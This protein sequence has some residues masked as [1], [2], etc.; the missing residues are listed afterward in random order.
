MDEE[1]SQG[2]KFVVRDRRRFDS[3]G[4]ERGEDAMTNPTSISFEKEAVEKEAGAPE[5]TAPKVAAVSAKSAAS[6][7][8]VKMSKPQADFAMADR[9]P[10]EDPEI[11]FS[12]FIISLATQSLMQLGEIKPPP[13]MNVPLDRESARHTID[14][15]GLLQQKTAGNLTEEEDKLMVEVLHNLR[16]SYVRVGQKKSDSKSVL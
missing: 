13:G 12:S 11:N 1:N 16:L 5:K 15:L 10:N 8:E 4:D 9:V 7:S 14:I 6:D 3:A 2:S